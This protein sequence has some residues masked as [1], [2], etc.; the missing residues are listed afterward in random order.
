[1]E[2]KDR[3]RGTEAYTE[4]VGAEYEVEMLRYRETADSGALSKARPVIDRL[5]ISWG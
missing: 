2:Y 4:R 5:Q 3:E 1:M